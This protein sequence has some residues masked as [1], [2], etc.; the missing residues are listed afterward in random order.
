V[1]QRILFGRL[2]KRRACFD[3][4][5]EGAR[6][7]APGL[8]LVVADDEM[9]NTDLMRQLRD[10]EHYTIAQFAQAI[11]AVHYANYRRHLAAEARRSGAAVA[12]GVES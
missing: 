3:L 11:G 8:E 4:M 12:A 9:V 6:A 5:V 1:N 7:I 2:V 10:S